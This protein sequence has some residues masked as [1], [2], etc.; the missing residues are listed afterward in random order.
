MNFETNPIR[1]LVVD[2]SADEWVLLNAELRFID[3]VKLIGFVHN[4]IEAIH[5]LRGMEA[6]GDRNSFP[7]PD[8][9]FLDFSM[10][11]CG[12]MGVLKFLQRQ[13]SRPRV[14]LWSNTLERVNIPLALHLGAD[15][16]CRKPLDGRELM[17]IIHHLRVHIFNDDQSL[18]SAAVTEQFRAEK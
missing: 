9:M 10:P 18:Y 13:F 16:V 6:F 8:L 15:M 17:K 7:Y 11:L 2:D 14:V 4:G 3:S 5:Y 1:I 12:G